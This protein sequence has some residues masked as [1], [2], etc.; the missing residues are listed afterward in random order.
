MDTLCASGPVFL[1]CL[2]GTSDDILTLELLLCRSTYCTFPECPAD[3][4]F[5]LKTIFFLSSGSNE[6][7][8]TLFDSRHLLLL[9]LEVRMQ[10]VDN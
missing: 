7:V 1:L 6:L 3:Q 4:L 9:V 10:H 8:F 2:K 5:V